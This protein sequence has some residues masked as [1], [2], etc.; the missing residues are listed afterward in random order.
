MT[1]IYRR[2]YISIFSILIVLLLGNFFRI[3]WNGRQLTKPIAGSKK[4]ATASSNL[5]KKHDR[6]EYDVIVK[7]NLFVNPG[8]GEDETESASASKLPETKLRLRLASTVI[9]NEGK[10]LA[11]IEDQVKRKQRIYKEGDYIV[12]SGQKSKVRVA[13]IER[14]QVVLE[15]NGKQE[16]LKMFEKKTYTARRG[17]RSRYGSS[18]VRRRHPRPVPRRMPEEIP[19]MGE[20][21]SEKLRTTPGQRSRETETH[22]TAK[23]YPVIEGSE[24]VGLRIRRVNPKGIYR[25]IGLINGD[26]IQSVNGQPVTEPSDI[27]MLN[28]ILKSGEPIELEI[29]RRNRIIKKSLQNY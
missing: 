23:F 4:K 6:S 7:R 11:V 22:E 18:R 17:G 19:L 3:W 16:V 28:E 2:L 10:S 29:K 9:T 24:V 20:R 1:K 5:I 27:E 8:L 14:F 21:F 26:I 15:R 25:R 12:I 13:K